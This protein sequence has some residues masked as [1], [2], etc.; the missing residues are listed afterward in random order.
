LITTASDIFRITSAA[1]INDS[2][3]AATAVVQ[4]LQSEKTG[5]WFCKILSYQTE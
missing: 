1:K 3:L 4:R 5:K 2:A